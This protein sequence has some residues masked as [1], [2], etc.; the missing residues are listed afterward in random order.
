MSAP[1][2]AVTER[3]CGCRRKKRNQR[4]A[5]GRWQC[6][7]TDTLDDRAMVPEAA[8]D[9]VSV[10]ILRVDPLADAPMTIRCARPDRFVTRFRAQFRGRKSRRPLDKCKT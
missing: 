10:G 8:H 9:G 6:E 3:A 2:D 4:A 1:D 7:P 5:L